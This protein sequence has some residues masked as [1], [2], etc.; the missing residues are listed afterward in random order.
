M[1][2]QFLRLGSSRQGKTKVRQRTRL[3]CARALESAGLLDGYVARFSIP[4]GAAS[5]HRPHGMGVAAIIQQSQRA[6]AKSTSVD[7]DRR[8]E[9]PVS[10]LPR[11]AGSA[12]FSI[13]EWFDWL[14]YILITR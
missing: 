3:A 5:R 6:V 10:V 8:E 4:R 1:N 11:F 12:A 14:D 7:W 13:L 9:A 2:Q